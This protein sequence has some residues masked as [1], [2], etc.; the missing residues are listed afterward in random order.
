M[1]LS[2][3]ILAS[4]G[5]AAINFW[6]EYSLPLDACNTILYLCDSETCSKHLFFSHLQH[7]NPFFKNKCSSF[8]HL[9]DTPTVLQILLDTFQGSM[10]RLIVSFVI[11]SIDK[12]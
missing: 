5:S 12:H 3:A 1:T 2:Q 9:N 11:N 6:E 7:M 4:P 8:H 10:W